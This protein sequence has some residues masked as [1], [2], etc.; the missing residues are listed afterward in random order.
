MDRLKYLLLA[1]T[2]TLAGCTLYL[3][4]PEEIPEEQRGFGEDYHEVNDSVDVTY[5]FNDNVRVLSKR[6]QD[7]YLTL[8][9]ADSI[10]Y[11]NDAIPDSDLPFAGGSVFSDCTDKLPYGLCS[12]VLSVTRENGMIKVVTQ[13]ADIDA[14]FKR[15]KLNVGKYVDMNSGRIDDNQPKADNDSTIYYQSVDELSTPQA[16]AYYNKVRRQDTQWMDTPWSTRGDNNG[17]EDADDDDEEDIESGNKDTDETSEWGITIDTRY[18]DEIGKRQNAIDA[19]DLFNL[20]KIPAK[21]K[22]KIDKLGK[23]AKKFKF[24][25]A[26]LK[27]GEAQWYVVA[28]LSRK[29]TQYVTA[30]VDTDNDLVEFKTID[31]TTWE[32]GIE[33]GVS[34]GPGIN[35][36]TFQPG[37]WLAKKTF[38]KNKPEILLEYEIEGP[39]IVIPLWG[40]LGLV[41]N[42]SFTIEFK[43]E[44]CGKVR[45]I[46]TTRKVTGTKAYK[47]N[48]TNI[49]EDE[50]K[51]SNGLKEASISGT[52]KLEMSLSAGVGLRIGKGVSIDITFGATITGGFEVKA[53]KNFAEEGNYEEQQVTHDNYVRLYSNWG[54]YIGVKVKAFFFTAVDEKFPFKPWDIFNEKYTFFPQIDTEVSKVKL[55][56]DEIKFTDEEFPQV[57]QAFWYTQ[58]FK[59]VG[60]YVS[61]FGDDNLLMPFVRIYEGK[62]KN[63]V[64]EDIYP[65]EA[66]GKSGYVVQNDNSKEYHYHLEDLEDDKLYRLVPC[67][68]WAGAVYEYPND[69]Q[70]FNSVSPYITLADVPGQESNCY[71]VYGADE[72]EELKEYSTYKNT[73]YHYLIAAY[74]TVSG[75]SYIKKFGLLVVVYNAKG[76][77]VINERLQIKQ[78]KFNTYTVGIDIYTSVKNPKIE[79]TPYAYLFKDG[80]SAQL[81]YFQKEKRTLNL[82]STKGTKDDYNE[83]WKYA[84]LISPKR[85]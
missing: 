28:D 71:Q 32:G 8:V 9:Q 72:T 75:W 82:S 57:I 78:D 47:G 83:F 20:P 59:H 43:V 56:E 6:I 4:E 65:E 51:K 35:E 19:M 11:F 48:V 34:A 27:G 74:P 73:P 10:L 67:I 1:L 52:A 63:R 60:I 54:F 26:F 81:Q 25:P 18:L 38:L 12:R 64:G 58:K 76:K 42:T 40:P 62:S 31:E 49:D 53:Y 14:V 2:A 13:Q 21:I 30:V 46:R 7:N 15:L 37:E 39:E 3:D 50:T 17:N 84:K 16:R 66:E 55:A 41:I 24:S 79:V 77:K 23:K 36:K 33:V 22:E 69:A 80:T 85:K 45:F 61:L 5:Q 70:Y 44:A 68:N 29:N